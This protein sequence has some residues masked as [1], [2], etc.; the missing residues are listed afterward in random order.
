MALLAR[1]NAMY[2]A[3]THDPAYW[4]RFWLSR[5][6]LEPHEYRLNRLGFALALVSIALM[7]AFGLMLYYTIPS[8]GRPPN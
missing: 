4:R 6:M 8:T 7:I 3:R 1:S 5:Q 2:Y